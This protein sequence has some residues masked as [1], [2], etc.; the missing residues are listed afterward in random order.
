MLYKNQ[1]SVS[2]WGKEQTGQESDFTAVT[3]L[4]FSRNLQL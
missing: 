2:D 3:T 1:D 4:L